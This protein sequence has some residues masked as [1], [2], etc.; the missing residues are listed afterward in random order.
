MA[1]RSRLNSRN[2]SLRNEVSVPE[3]EWFLPRTLPDLAFVSTSQERFQ[4]DIEHKNVLQGSPMTSKMSPKSIKS[5]VFLPSGSCVWTRCK[6]TWKGNFTQSVLDTF[7][8]S[9]NEVISSLNSTCSCLHVYFSRS[10]QGDIWTQKCRPKAP[11]W[12]PKWC[13]NDYKTRLSYRVGNQCLTW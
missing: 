7:S 6:K 9:K 11:K 3:Y 8:S 13:K 10:S 5:Y 1:C 12:A 4:E 2:K